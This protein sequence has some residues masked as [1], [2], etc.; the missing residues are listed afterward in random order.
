MHYY[1][2]NP[3]KSP[4]IC[5]LFDCPQIGNLMTPEQ[6][7]SNHTSNFKRDSCPPSM[8][9]S[10]SGR[11]IGNEYYIFILILACLYK[12]NIGNVQICDKYI[13]IY[14]L[15]VYMLHMSYV[16]FASD[17]SP[18]RLLSQCFVF[19]LTSQQAN[20]PETNIHRP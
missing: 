17:Q 15:Y 18:K 7:T 6:T 8:D 9:S 16:A 1:R 13:Y 10:D 4:Y 14:Y 3:P 19:S 5:C 12:V 20:L 2:G 11:G